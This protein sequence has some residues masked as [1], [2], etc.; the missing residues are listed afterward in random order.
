MTVVIHY[1]KGNVIVTLPIKY[2]LVALISAPHEWDVH[3]IWVTLEISS[4]SD[5]L[6]NGRTLADLL[7]ADVK[8]VTLYAKY[9]RR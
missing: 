9:L 3:K 5:I 7:L 6:Y 4:K 8:N 1:A 2:A